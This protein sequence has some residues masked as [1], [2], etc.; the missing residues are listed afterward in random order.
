MKLVI[1]EDNEYLCKVMSKY[2]TKE[3]NINIVGI[4]NNGI[5]GMNLIK[6][7]SPDIAI[8][9][10]IMPKKDGI[11]LLEELSE[12]RK[13]NKTNYIVLT[14]ISNDL[15]IRHILDLGAKYVLLKP[16]GLDIILKRLKYIQSSE[17]YFN[18]KYFPSAK[19]INEYISET[20][21]RI[22][23]IS[24]T[25]G[26]TYLKSAIIMAYN[27]PSILK[28][29]T[30][31]LYPEIAKQNKTNS[32]SVE[33]AIRYVIET[34]WNKDKEDYELI[35]FDINGKKPKNGYFIA[36]LADYLKKSISKKE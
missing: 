18:E 14:A 15:I 19:G 11:S 16:C 6:N 27:N 4:A 17:N 34:T 23:I 10:L 13:I 8:I 22:G 12:Q 28:G 3:S 5:D 32:S 7:T 21:N 20:L 25:K 29:I 9:D 2:F 35:G 31:C 24:N 30:K 33:R 1:I 36:V 26:Y